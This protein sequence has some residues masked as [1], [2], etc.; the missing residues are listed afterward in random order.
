MKLAIYPPIGIARLGNSPD[1]FFVGPEQVGS[2]GV[3]IRADGTEVP[4][5]AFKD[6]NYRVKRQ[7]ARFHLFELFDDGRPPQPATL[8]ADAVVIWSVGV[9]NKKDAVFRP[10]APP[11][12]PR[13][14]RLDPARA[15]RHIHATATVSGTSAA[16]V[17]LDG[18][19]RGTTVNL[20]HA[21]TD[22]SGRL[23]VTAG[24]G[25][26]ATLSN[27]PASI[28][29]DFYN[30]PDWFDDIC[31]GPI[32]ATVTLASGAPIEATS[33][34]LCTAP[35]D[36]SPVTLGIVTLY[37][38]LL[39]LAYKSGWL[40]ATSRPFFASDVQP[41]IERAANHRFVS[42]NPAWSK[43]ST[44]WTRL[45]DVAQAQRPLRLEVASLV[46]EAENAIQSFQLRDW[47]LD[48]LDA[49]A[50]GDFDP[51]PRPG[52]GTCDVLT[53]AAL[54]GAVGQGFFPGIEAGINVVDPSVWLSSGFEF[55]MDARMIE[56]GDVTAH[57][58][59]PWQAD[60]LKCGSGWWPA[61]RPNDAPQAA[62]TFRPWL[63]PTMNH[64]KLVEDVM[65]LGIISA[66]GTGAVVE[67][68]RHPSLGS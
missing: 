64:Q 12:R 53:R 31:D 16:P 19:Y 23:V 50:S 33:A 54:D 17:A 34:W 21:R 62:G 2:P 46:R 58:A 3:E 55:R 42:T 66:D 4:V 63:R 37:D 29:D 56:P 25:R 67:Q 15:D 68:G 13:S 22:R 48:A 26:S 8:P 36:F 47:Q 60:F 41:M 52:R 44:D 27:P 39:E 45:A 51:G 43:I 57:M 20:G 10:A 24:S 35:P 7:A 28:G 38:V 61:Q 1:E 9:A 32:R 14:V 5:S 65:K 30:N 6:K 49:W 11:D 59:L 40:K 18:V